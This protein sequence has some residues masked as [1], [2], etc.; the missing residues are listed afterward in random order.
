MKAK[1]FNNVLEH[2]KQATNL[3]SLIEADKLPHALLLSGPAGVGKKR[4]AL[5]LAATLLDQ[6]NRDLFSDISKNIVHDFKFIQKK[7]DK[8]D[9]D[10]EQ[11]R[12]LTSYLN[13]RP[14][15]SK[16][17]VSIID[18]AHLMNSSSYNALLTTLEEPTSFSKLILI[19]NN[20]HRI[21]PTILSRCQTINFGELSK[22]SICKIF[23]NLG[24]HDF[25][26]KIELTETETYNSMDQFDISPFLDQLGLNITDEAALQIHLETYFAEQQSSFKAF[27]QIFK[28]GSHTLA[29]SYISELSGAKDESRSKILLFF[30]NF[31]SFLRTKMR[32]DHVNSDKWSDLLIDTVEVEKLVLERSGNFIIQASN[33]LV[34]KI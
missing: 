22:K 29:L 9:I 8:R 6:P 2:E 18:D 24:C 20:A 33:L 27:E 19:S 1:Y 23:N 26:T 21:L 10:I 16:Y 4:F 31:K 7:A 11:V 34:S 32:V 30:K 28:T 3:L 14:Y 5:A 15:N 17:V 13:I 12:E 25:A